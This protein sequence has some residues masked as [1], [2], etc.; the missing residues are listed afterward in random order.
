MPH[1][2]RCERCGWTYELAF[3][4]GY[5]YIEHSCWYD[6]EK[7]G[8]KMADIS[9]TGESGP[10]EEQ[11]EDRPGADICNKGLFGMGI[12]GCSPSQK[13]VALHHPYFP[14]KCTAPFFCTRQAFCRFIKSLLRR[15]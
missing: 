14:D 8:E 9:D 11:L 12:Y 15:G 4:N 1:Y 2:A 7:I 5:A 13:H 3:K 10:E 6:C